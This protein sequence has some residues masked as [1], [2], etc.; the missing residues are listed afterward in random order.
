MRQGSHAGGGAGRVATFMVSKG[1]RIAA[2]IAAV[3]ALGATS[4]SAV[5]AASADPNQLV[6]VTSNGLVDPASAVLG[7]GGTILNRYH[8]INGVEASVPSLGVTN[9][10]SL[11]SLVVTPD[12]NVS[13]QGSYSSGPHTPSDAYLQETGANQ[14]A[15]HCFRMTDWPRTFC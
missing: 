9:L 13:V 10:M 14:L 15:S 2:S 11:S 4:L 6:I 3:C 12:V 1:G 7:V 5:P 8:V